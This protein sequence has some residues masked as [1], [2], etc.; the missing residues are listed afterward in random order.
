MTSLDKPWAAKSPPVASVSPKVLNFGNQ[1]QQTTS[2]PQTVTLSNTGTAPLSIGSIAISGTN[3]GD[4]A[5]TTTCGAS[6]AAGANCTISVTFKPTHKGARSATL[7]IIDN[8]NAVANS[9]QNVSLSGTG[10]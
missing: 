6:L 5:R 3:A 7:T 4:F 8:S 10:Q 1:K 2:A 9:A